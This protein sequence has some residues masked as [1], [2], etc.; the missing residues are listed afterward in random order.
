[1]ATKHLL[2]DICHSFTQHTGV[3]VELTSVGGVDAAKRI[4]AGEKF[5]VVLLASDAID[6]LIDS[7][8]LMAGSRCDWVNSAVS[9]A[10]KSGQPVPDIGTE[11]QLREAVL[12]ASTL[13]YSTGPSGTY[14]ENLFKRWGVFDTLKARI[15]VAPPGTPVG[16]L[17]SQGQAELGFQQRSELI[18]QTGIQLVGDLPPEVAHIT[19]FSAGMGLAATQSTQRQQAVQDFFHC[20]ISPDQAAVKVLHGMVW[21]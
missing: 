16:L 21:L 1:M 19:T 18:H 20:L 4:Q 11:Q 6:T 10:V 17:V 12:S 15:L 5:D 3:G 2:A 13:C 9:M 7:G 14:L 8:H